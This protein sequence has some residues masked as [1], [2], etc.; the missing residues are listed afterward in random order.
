M[1]DPSSQ[2]REKVLV[3]S[4]TKNNIYVMGLYKNKD[5]TKLQ[6]TLYDQG[7]SKVCKVLYPIWIFCILSVAI[8]FAF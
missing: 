7:C 3:I 2:T 6:N 5:Q 1:Q 8:V 4:L